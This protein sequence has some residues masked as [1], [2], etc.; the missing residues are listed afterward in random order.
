M[1]LQTEGRAIHLLPAWPADWNADFKL[2]APCNTT[3]EGRV[4]GGKLT[5]LKI[6]PESRRAD[7][8]IHP[9]NP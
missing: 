5:T 8:V 9:V 6:T 2:R 1:L 3:V 7:V 4:E